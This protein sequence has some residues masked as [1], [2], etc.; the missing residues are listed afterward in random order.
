MNAASF[1]RSRS[2]AA[3]PITTDAA[4]TKTD[5][6]SD[7]RLKKAASDFESILVTSWLEKMRNSFSLD[8]QSEDAMPGAD[9]MTALATQSV[10]Q[11]MAAR[12]GFGIGKVLYDR[13]RPH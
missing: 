10:A 11:A 13:L 8:G 2:V 4:A 12:G 7:A 1:T 6:K 5:P 9:S 3:E